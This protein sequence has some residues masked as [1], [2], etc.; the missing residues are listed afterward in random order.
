MAVQRTFNST[1]PT[2]AEKT[3]ETK[4]SYP[5]FFSDFGNAMNSG[6]GKQ[7]NPVKVLI[8]FMS[9]KNGSGLSVERCRCSNVG[10]ESSS[11]VQGDS[12]QVQLQGA[13]MF[14]WIC[15]NGKKKNEEKSIW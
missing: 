2:N 4:Q 10:S 8:R 3:I 15:Q 14:R 7:K 5:I 1:Y 12:G 11:L 9:T 13:L 6:S